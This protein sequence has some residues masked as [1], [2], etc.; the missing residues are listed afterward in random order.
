[1][2]DDNKKVRI[3]L[4]R[5]IWPDELMQIE[6]KRKKRLLIISTVVAFVFVF[7][8][9]WVLGGYNNAS[10]TQQQNTEAKLDVVFD[11]MSKDWYFAKED[12]Q[13]QEHLLD[14][15]LYGMTSSD[16]DPHT[17][18]LSSDELSTF[19]QSINMNFVGIGVQFI[20]QDGM[21]MIEKVF[22]NSPAEEAGVLAGDIINKV[23]G[24]PVAGLS[25]DEIKELV[26]GESGSKVEIEF[27]RQGSLVTL[28]ITRREVSGTAYGQMVDDTI[29]YIEIF[30]FG[31][32]TGEEVGAY[33]KDLTDAG[34]TKLIIDV[35]DD[36]GGYLEALVDIASYFVNKGE[37]VMKQEYADGSIKE[38]Y[39]GAGLYTNIDGIVVLVNENTASA[40]EV[41][42]LTL[43]EV[44]DDVTVL[45]TTTFGKGTVQ[46]TQGFYD[47]SALKYTVSKWLSPNGT[48]INGV[49]IVPDVEV[50]L[51]PILDERYIK[52]EEGVSYTFDQVSEYVRIM[53]EAL[54]F[55]DYKVDRMDGYF[56]QSTE[57]ALKQFEQDHQLEVD[58]VL[59]A[60]TIEVLLSSITKTWALSKDKDVQYHA[61]IDLL[62]K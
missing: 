23:D 25:A 58:G 62:R 24:T 57:D 40:A 56:D 41:L 27:L 28:D 54:D 34:M 33:L 29:G 6:K 8:M 14:Q 53:Q 55:L 49:G 61:A 16:V 26:R 2:M 36:G 37:V 59:D 10:P 45:G 17:T 7:I 50:Q 13:I 15:A 60:S 30:Q 21:N 9:G 43:S 46:V 4:E 32:T 5:H 35:R 18:Y 19:T 48:S 20:A 1:M 31:E 44:R 39:A 52:L 47:G 42:T 38:S 51:H 11:I 12:E 22:K 3:Q